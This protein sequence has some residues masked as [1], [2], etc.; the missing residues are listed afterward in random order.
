MP[1]EP[2]NITGKQ[3]SDYRKKNG[4]SQQDLATLLGVSLPTIKRWES[5]NNTPRDRHL[6]ALAGIL[7]VAAA[8]SAAASTAATTPLALG[9]LGTALAALAGPLPIALST[10]AP[11]FPL[12][13]LVALLT[14]LG[15]VAAFALS[16]TASKSAEG[17][18]HEPAQEQVAQELWRVLEQVSLSFPIPRTAEERSKVEKVQLSVEID[19]VLL[20]KFR[21]EAEMR[22]FTQSRILESLLWLFLEAPPLSF[23]TNAGVGPDLTKSSAEDDI[24]HTDSLPGAELPG[25]N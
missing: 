7:G 21:E 25:Y 17:I 14:G 22:G 6:V 10:V 1:Q 15:A 5:G 16:K 2:Y 19:R 20:D 11:S 13:P 9:A 3:I 24:T 4:L 18:Q 8:G 12:A 23:Q